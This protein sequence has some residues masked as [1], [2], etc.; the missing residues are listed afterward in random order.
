[1]RNSATDMRYHLDRAM[2]T[3]SSMRRQLEA[4]QETI[5]EGWVP[6]AKVEETV[7]STLQA[8][9]H[10]NPLKGDCYLIPVHEMHAFWDDMQTRLRSEGGAKSERG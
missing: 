10:S 9:R 3:A 6:I 1:M 4:M 2:E 5:R 8:Y 7:G